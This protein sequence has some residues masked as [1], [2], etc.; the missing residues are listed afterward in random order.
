MV[1][2][3]KPEEAQQLIASGDVDVVDVRNTREWSNGHIPEARSVPLE[4][5]EADPRRALPRDRVVFVCAKG[6]RSR[7][8]A[9]LAEA[10]GLHD[11]FNVDGGT[12]AWAGAGLPLV[13][14]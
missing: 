6:V 3:L 4:A 2:T 5:L 11:L 1:H 9:K 7:V 14:G 10:I 13:R 8:A 12:L